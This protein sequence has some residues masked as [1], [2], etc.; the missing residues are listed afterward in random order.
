MISKEQIGSQAQ[1]AL[2]ERLKAAAKKHNAR[3]SY[4]IAQPQNS[5][6]RVYLYIDKNGV[7]YSV[8]EYAEF[9]EMIHDAVG[10][11]EWAVISATSKGR[12]AMGIIE[13]AIIKKIE[14]SEAE[15]AH[16]R[17]IAPGVVEFCGQ[18][19]DGRRVEIDMSDFI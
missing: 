17:P 7:L 19:A 3:Y 15:L 18:T 5:K 8:R 14:N 16:V 2:F 13:Q 1:K 4:Y 12:E 10:P 6:L 9:S 11:M